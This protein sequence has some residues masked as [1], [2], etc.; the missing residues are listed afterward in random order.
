MSK[1]KDLTETEKSNI[2]LLKNLKHSNREIAKQINRSK[3]VINVFLSNPENYGFK[4]DFKRKKK[5]GPKTIKEI[6]RLASNKSTTSRQIKSNLK[7]NAS[8]RTILRYL[9]DSGNLKYIK[10]QFKPPLTTDHKK[11]RLE[12]AEKYTGWD[13]KWSKVV[14]SDEKKFNLD[15]PDGFAYYWHDLRKEKL[16]FSKRVQG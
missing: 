16:I 4:R 7:C 14:F 2:L 13:Q 15:G 9:D 12:F 6:C 11:R 1:G 8:P 3:D 5:D 10:K